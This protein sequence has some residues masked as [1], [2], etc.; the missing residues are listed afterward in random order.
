MPLPKDRQ[1]VWLPVRLD[2]A[3]DRKWLSPYRRSASIGCWPSE[4]PKVRGGGHASRIGRINRGHPLRTQNIE[5]DVHPEVEIVKTCNCFL[6]CMSCSQVSNRLQRERGHRLNW[7]VWRSSF[8][9]G[10]RYPN[11][12]TSAGWMYGAR[13]SIAVSRR[14]AFGRLQIS[15]AI[16][17]QQTEAASAAQCQRT[18]QEVAA[19]SAKHD[20]KK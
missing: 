2:R 6:C 10:E 5:V 4:L 20:R 17:K 12:T 8:G 7:C 13:P 3:S 15:V 9:A 19:I 11:S 1:L 18:S 14:G 16:D